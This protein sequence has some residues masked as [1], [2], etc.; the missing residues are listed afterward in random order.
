MTLV[1]Q[2]NPAYKEF[3]KNGHRRT[4]TNTRLT[5][6]KGIKYLECRLCMAAS[7]KARRDRRKARKAADDGQEQQF[8]CEEE[9]GAGGAVLR[10][11]V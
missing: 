5:V 1:R 6:R 4:K 8:R 9:T 10:L 11:P 2:D 7:D 3:C